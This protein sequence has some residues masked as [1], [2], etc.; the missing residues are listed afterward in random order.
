MFYLDWNRYN[1][2]QQINNIR[3][4]V[5]N[6]LLSNMIRYLII[7]FETN[8]IGSFRPPT[9]YPI[10][11]SYR[12]V[13]FACRVIESYTTLIK[14]ATDINWPEK[15]G[16]CKWTVDQLNREGKTIDEVYNRIEKYL[17]ND[18]YI[19]GHNV[20]FDIG[21]LA[22]HT[23]KDKIQYQKRIC[24]MKKSREF[25]QLEYANS[26]K[27]EKKKDNNAPKKYKW[28]KLNELAEKLDIT[29]ES[30]DLHDAEYDVEITHKCL[31]ELLKKRIIT[32]V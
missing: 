6:I 12:L 14:G 20:D 25:C 10:Q 16:E 19:V 23:K 21:C 8:G 5:L 3:K 31:T 15:L 18:T 22:Y 7:D 26:K 30:N 17:D 27:E 9:Q 28:P 2:K 13:D 1:H 32:I 11:V 4:N 29:Y 24:T